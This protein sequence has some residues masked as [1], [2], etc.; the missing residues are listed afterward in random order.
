M[1]DCLPQQVRTDSKPR[2]AS[3][4]LA[5]RYAISSLA[6]TT[7]RERLACNRDVERRRGL[8]LGQLANASREVTSKASN[9]TRLCCQD[10][11][12]ADGFGST[13]R[14]SQRE[15]FTEFELVA[16]HRL[17][18]DHCPSAPCAWAHAFQPVEL[19]TA[20]VGLSKTTVQRQCLRPTCLMSPRHYK[21]WK[22]KHDLTQRRHP[23]RS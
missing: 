16:D 14:P 17:P 15:N 21:V 8:K 20:A 22:N 7:S 18:K 9:V 3:R 2:R 4:T 19:S 6:A 11:D 23:R 12:V 10:L 1:A 13:V 5:A